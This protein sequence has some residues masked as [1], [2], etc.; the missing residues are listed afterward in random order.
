MQQDVTHLKN[1]VSEI[2]MDVKELIAKLDQR[3]IDMANHNS[4]EIVKATMQYSEELSQIK[5]EKANKWV[6]KVMW[7]GG[8]II[9][10]S[11]LV[12]I[13]GLVVKK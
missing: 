9:G 6:E 11:I 12:A 10:A 8:T 3:F 7:G 5:K 1:D 2:K 4:S 13:I